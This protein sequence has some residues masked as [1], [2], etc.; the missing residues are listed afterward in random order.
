MRIVEAV[1]KALKQILGRDVEKSDLIE[2]TTIND[3]MI[4]RG[5]ER[6]PK[7]WFLLVKK[8]FRTGSLGIS[9]FPLPSSEKP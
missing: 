8:T 9:N 1:E 6:P 4:A 5:Q 2:C 7:T 3:L